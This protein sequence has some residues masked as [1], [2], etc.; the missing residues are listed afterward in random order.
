MADLR[1]SYYMWPFHQCPTYPSYPSYISYLIAVLLVSIVYHGVELA[2]N[3]TSPLSLFLSVFLTHS[4]EFSYKN[5]PASAYYNRRCLSSDANRKEHGKRAGSA[6]VQEP[7]RRRR[8]ITPDVLRYNVLILLTCR[9]ENL[10]LYSRLFYLEV[11]NH[12]FIFNTLSALMIMMMLSLSLSFS[13]SVFLFL[14][15]R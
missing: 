12:H 13:P 2:S 14:S 10:I 15:R 5:V 11:F 9:R 3:L 1:L 6:S 4:S 7:I 8:I